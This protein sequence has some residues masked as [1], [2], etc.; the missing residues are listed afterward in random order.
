MTQKRSRQYRRKPFA[1]A[2]MLLI[3]A[4]R[5]M[6]ESSF[7]QD[8][9]P[10]DGWP[11]PEDAFLQEAAARTRAIGPVADQIK[12]S[13]PYLSALMDLFGRDAAVHAAGG[14]AQEIANKAS[15]S[16][17]GVGNDPLNDLSSISTI[18]RAQAD[19]V[20]LSN[21]NYMST[22]NCQP[23]PYAGQPNTWPGGR[24]PQLP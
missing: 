19:A 7:G 5:P 15:E 4:A 12:N 6:I 8:R 18:T 9:L 13:V 2:L 22:C 1:W 23:T 20:N 14:V 17:A 21:P 24:V 16:R 11:V 3:V 10:L